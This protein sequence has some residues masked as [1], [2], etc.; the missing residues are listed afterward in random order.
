MKIHTHQ[1]IF[2]SGISAKRQFTHSLSAEFP[3]LSRRRRGLLAGLAL[4]FRD[5]RHGVAKLLHVFVVVFGLHGYVDIGRLH[6]R[7]LDG[8]SIRQASRTRARGSL[9]R[10]KLLLVLDLKA[11]SQVIAERLVLGV[12]GEVRGAV[13]ALDVEGLDDLWVVEELVLDQVVA[14]QGG[15]VEVQTVLAVCPLAPA[16]AV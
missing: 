12:L 16:A 14:D 13:G 3:F 9:H 4:V 5:R 7:S 6:A 10:A 2:N 1:P 15:L 8:S 11:V